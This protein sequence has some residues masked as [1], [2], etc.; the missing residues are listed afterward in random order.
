MAAGAGIGRWL[1]RLFEAGLVAKAVFAAGEALS[2]FGLLFAGPSALRRLLEWMTRH[3]LAQD[4]TDR[5]ALWLRDLAGGVSGDSQHFYAVYLLSHGALKL[6]LVAAL[7]ARL[8]WAYPASM[9][10]LAG[11]ILYQMQEWTLTGSPMLL[12]LSAFDLA[13][14]ALTWR[15][16]R[17]MRRKKAT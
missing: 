1:H 9:V 15:E 11:F 12:A 4:P 17:V 10:V 14:I 5:M 7:A 6:A 3:E 8:S 13:M 16:F 2:G